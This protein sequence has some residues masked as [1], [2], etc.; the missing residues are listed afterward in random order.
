M[1]YSLEKIK[2]FI[3]IYS[4]L[5]IYIFISSQPWTNGNIITEHKSIA[6][7]VNEHYKH[8][9]R[10]INEK[11]RWRK[12]QYRVTIRINV[13]KNKREPSSMISIRED[14]HFAY[15][16]WAKHIFDAP[17]W[18]LC[19]PRDTVHLRSLANRRDSI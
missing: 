15:L 18:T 14:F 6:V 7:K 11:E 5:L 8:I 19:Q 10:I 4:Y 1:H 12:W 17:L 13:S 9:V 2:V 16:R 3:S